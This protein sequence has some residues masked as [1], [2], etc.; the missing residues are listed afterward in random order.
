MSLHKYFDFHLQVLNSIFCLY[1]IERLRLQ[2]VL[3][4]TIFADFDRE[5]EASMRTPLVTDEIVKLLDNYFKLK[6][7]ANNLDMS[8]IQN[9]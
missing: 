7:K 1:K 9:R 3:R 4:N 8:E 2:S 5:L 6:P